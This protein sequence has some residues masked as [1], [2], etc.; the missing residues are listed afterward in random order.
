VE[1]SSFSRN[2]ANPS[3]F[4]KIQ[5]LIRASLAATSIRKA[6]KRKGHKENGLNLS[7][8]DNKQSNILHNTMSNIN[9]LFSTS[10]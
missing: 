8:I 5:W 10:K 1:K 4:E 3:V 6:T 2:W 7:I 9:D